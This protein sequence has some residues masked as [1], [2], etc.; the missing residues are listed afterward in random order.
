MSCDSQQPGT[1]QGLEGR[2]ATSRRIPGSLHLGATGATRLCPHFMSPLGNPADARAT[3]GAAAALGGSPALGPKQAWS[4][5]EAQTDKHSDTGRTEGSLFTPMS[6]M[7]EWTPHLQKAQTPQAW[8]FPETGL[9]LFQTTQGARFTKPPGDRP[10][11]A[12][13]APRTF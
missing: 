10:L 4:L 7:R 3:L 8:A 13:R 12:W 11:G 9:P 6:G 1:C 2:Q 5:L